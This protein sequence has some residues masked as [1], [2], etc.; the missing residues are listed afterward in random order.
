[1]KNILFLWTLLCL[2]QPATAQEPASQPAIA[3]KWAPTGLFV[4]SISLQGEYNFGNRSL[5]AKIGLPAN[6]RR[7][8]TYQEKDAAFSMKATSFLAG[9]RLYLSKK[10]LKGFYLEPYF[11][12]VHHTAEGAGTGTLTGESVVMDFTNDYNGFGVG[13]QLGAQFLIGKRFLIDLFFFGPEIN[14]STNNFKAVETSNALAWNSVQA[15][16][17]ENNIRDFINQFPFVKNI[18][19]VRVDKANRTVMANF[20]GALPGFRTGVSFGFLF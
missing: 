19:D 10:Q 18:T 16:E 14:S 4:G 12:Y 2:L 15:S 1:M 20:K 8:F 5:T 3:L 7:S 13:A 9:Y 17:A 11:K 6:T